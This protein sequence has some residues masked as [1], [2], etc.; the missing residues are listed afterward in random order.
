[1][2]RIRHRVLALIVLPVLLTSCT[3]VLNKTYMREGQRSVSFE[4]L[5]KEPEHYRGRILILGGIIVRTK[6][7][8]AGSE[9]EAVQVPVDRYG[10]FKE[11]GRSEGRFLAILAKDKKSLDPIV[12]RRGRRVTLAGDFVTTRKGKIDEMEYTYP[13]F[14]IKEVYLWPKERNYP[15]PSYY[16]PW[17]YPY[18]YYFWDPWWSHYYYPGPVPPPSN[19]RTPPPQHRKEQEPGHERK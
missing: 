13:V 15:P 10:Y 16:D 14:E 1:M 6:F 5:R 4:E 9:L 7:T 18:P 2:R 3:P 19:P 8:E 17:F 12:Y 11:R